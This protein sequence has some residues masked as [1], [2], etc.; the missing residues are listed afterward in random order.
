M[1]LLELFAGSRSIGKIAEELNFEVFSSDI[2]NF[3]NINYV[4]DI[5]NFETSKV[6]FIPNVIWASPPCTFFSVAS[7]GKHWN[8]NNTP[9]TDSAKL[10]VEIV[11]KTLQII[12]FYLELNPNLIWFIENPTG[13]LRKLEVIKGNFDRATI[14]YCSYGDIR[15]K[16]TDIWSNNIYN[17]LFNIKGWKPKNR[18]Y[19][20]NICHHIK[21][22]RGS[23]TGTQGI[24]GAYERS[25]IPK[26]LCIDILKSC[27]N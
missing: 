6:P 2:N 17:P 10:G 18:C 26:Q 24:K 21:A 13:K 12:N 20:N 9:K 16:P 4:T 22:P 5:L 8:K 25:K 15:M 14:T 19:P 3:K 27:I 11:N 1:Y 7:I 23:T